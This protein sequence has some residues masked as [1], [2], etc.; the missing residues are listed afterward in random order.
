MPWKVK[1]QM[2]LRLEFV[3]MALNPGVNIRQLC[4]NHGISATTGYKWLARFQEAGASA[5]QNQSRR[6]HRSPQRT[7]AMIEEKVVALRREH[8]A[9]GGRK[10]HRRLKDLGHGD[11]PAP[12]TITNILHRHDLIGAQESESPQPWQRFARC[13][14]NELW[15]LDFKG[16]FPLNNGRCHPLTMLDDHSRFNVL[17]QACEDQRQQTVQDA[18]RRVFE[19]YG[20][21][22]AILCD[23]GAPWGACGGDEH[24]GLSI[25]LLRLG[26]GVYHG[27]AYHPQTQGKEERFHRTLKAEVIQRGGWSHCAQVQ[28]RFDDWRSI[29]NCQRPHEALEMATP[30][31]RYRLS[32][33]PYPSQLPELEYATGVQ[34]RRVDQNGW[35]SYNH[36]SWKV[37]RAFKKQIVGVR[38]TAIDGVMEILFG[39]HTIKTI[40]LR[41]E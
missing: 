10:L 9:W 37:G 4:R 22:D 20:L 23:N 28:K 14:P 21:P 16:P 25:W 11:L 26:V 27:R 8:P 1:N 40:N 7:E 5:L 31:S 13:A 39:T 30:A 12:S 34:I 29:Y 18:L 19:R 35:I 33:R 17:L 15:Q 41:E 36:Q 3:T 24:T 6:P 38:T 2:S 32:Q